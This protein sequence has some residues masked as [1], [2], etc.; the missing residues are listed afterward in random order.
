MI[1]DG[2]PWEASW[3]FEWTDP[4]TLVI[5]FHT[6]EKVHRAETTVNE[7]AIRY[8]PRQPGINPPR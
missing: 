4:A 5:G 3:G 2:A 1:A 6:S 8:Q 7:I